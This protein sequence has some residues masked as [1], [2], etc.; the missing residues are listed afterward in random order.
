MFMY[1]YASAMSSD[2]LGLI[3]LC[4]SNISSTCLDMDI[5]LIDACSLCGCMCSSLCLLLMFLVISCAL[6]FALSSLATCK[7]SKASK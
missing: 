6:C 4:M 2:Y 3:S 5:L 1:L 7:M